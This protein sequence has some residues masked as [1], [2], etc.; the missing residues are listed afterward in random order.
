MIDHSGITVP[1]ELFEKTVAFYEEALKPLGYS[2]KRKK[3][4]VVA[5]LGDNW[6]GADF[7]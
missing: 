1:P 5:G 4:G 3:E 7:W 2:V 6:Y